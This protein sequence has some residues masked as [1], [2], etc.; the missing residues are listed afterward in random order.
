MPPSTREL[1]YGLSKCLTGTIIGILLLSDTLAEHFVFFRSWSCWPASEINF[2]S[3]CKQVC[4]GEIPHKSF[5]FLFYLNDNYDLTNSF[6]RL[7]RDT[8]ESGS[9]TVSLSHLKL[10]TPDIPLKSL[11]VI[12]SDNFRRQNAHLLASLKRKH[13]K[14]EASA[15][16][17]KSLYCAWHSPTAMMRGESLCPGRDNQ[18]QYFSRSCII[19]TSSSLFSLN[20]TNPICKNSPYSWN[21]AS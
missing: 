20:G 13:R 7:E 9:W 8:E 21:F 18:C 1:T 11:T 4:I 5:S 14:T 10:S 2:P 6:G 17:N 15:V 12:R 16:V 19:A 3:V